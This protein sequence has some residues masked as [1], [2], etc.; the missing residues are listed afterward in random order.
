[1][2]MKP[3][4]AQPAKKY[5][6]K[7]PIVAVLVEKATPPER[8]AV[9]PENAQQEQQELKERRQQ[10]VK[11]LASELGETKPSVLS[12]LHAIV[13]KL[14]CEQA[15]HLLDEARQVEANGGMM[16][17]NGSRRRTF[18]GVYFVLVR[19]HHPDVA[20]QPTRVKK[21]QP[22]AH[23]EEQPENKLT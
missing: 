23:L 22:P 10:T 6:R 8:Q 3:K 11:T 5:A 1:M 17:K 20:F 7:S 4:K 18:G 16:I 21:A 13:K 19:T 2:D 15:L 12:Q 9:L 14:G